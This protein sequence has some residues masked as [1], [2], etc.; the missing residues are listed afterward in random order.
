MRINV[1]IPVSN[2]TDEH[3][4]AEEAEIAMAP[5]FYN[6]VWKGNTKIPTQ[7]TLGKGHIAFF[8]N[9]KQWTLKRYA[10]LHEECTRRGFEGI[11]DKSYRWNEWDPEEDIW[12]EPT[13]IDRR[14]VIE[15]IK[16]KIINST[17]TFHYQRVK[18]SK[19]DGVKL[20]DR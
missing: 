10:E 8:M 11:K 7:F 6:R 13:N 15:R 19:K 17:G 2:L 20:L 4:R 18:I 3:L 9:K 16:D 5:G 1:G 12:Y 14:L